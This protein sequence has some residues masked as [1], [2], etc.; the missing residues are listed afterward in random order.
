MS[1]FMIPRTSQVSGFLGWGFGVGAGGNA[2]I[3]RFAGFGSRAL[4]DIS[5]LH[6]LVD[7]QPLLRLRTVQACRLATPHI[8]VGPT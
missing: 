1:L 6:T 8:R 3:F 7:P 2:Y 5:V 4:V